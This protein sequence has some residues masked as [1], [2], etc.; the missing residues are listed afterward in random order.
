[1]IEFLK[2]SWEFFGLNAPWFS[3]IAALGLLLWPAYEVIRL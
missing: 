3:W 2:Y 1:M